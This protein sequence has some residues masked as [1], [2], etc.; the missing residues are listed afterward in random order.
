MFLLYLTAVF[1]LETKASNFQGM[2]SRYPHLGKLVP[3]IFDSLKID[4][5]DITVQLYSV[6]NQEM[7]LCW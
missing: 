5:S 4:G 7:S 6:S 3:L 2:F 1:H